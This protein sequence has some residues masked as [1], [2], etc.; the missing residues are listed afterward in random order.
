MKLFYNKSRHGKSWMF[1][2]DVFKKKYI[3]TIYCDKSKCILISRLLFFFKVCKI[4][5]PLEGMPKTCLLKPWPSWHSSAYS[6][7]H[8]SPLWSRLK[9]RTLNPVCSTVPHWR[10]ICGS[11][12]RSLSCRSL[13]CPVCPCMKRSVCVGGCLWFLLPWFTHSFWW[14]DLELIQAALRFLPSFWASAF[15]HSRFQ[16]YLLFTK[17]TDFVGVDISIYRYILYMYSS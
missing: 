14:F 15:T 7:I 17:S 12:K 11:S 1:S 6:A 13:V 9:P 5:H 4:K 2:W 8:L 16:I 3:P 10:G